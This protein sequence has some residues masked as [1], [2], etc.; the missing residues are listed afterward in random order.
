MTS[1]DA[2][3]SDASFV[4]ATA[5]VPRGDRPD[6][7]LTAE[8]V[9]HALRNDELEMWFQPKLEIATG[10]IVG[11]EALLRWRHPEHGVL[12][13]AD[14]LSAADRSGL[15]PQI[16]RH[17][18]DQSLMVAARWRAA[19]LLMPVAVNVD[20]ADLADPSLAHH[21]EALLDAHDLP[22]EL[23]LLE[24]TENAVLQD[25]ADTSTSVEQL[26][27]LGVRLAI[28]DFGVGYS[29]LSRLVQFQLAELKVDMSLIQAMRTSAQ[30]TTA[31]R[32]VIDLGHALGMRVVA[33]GV[34]D[35]R[36]L[37]SLRSLGCDTAQGYLVAAAMPADD[38]HAWV[39]ER[40]T[41]TGRCAPAAGRTAGGRGWWLHG[42]TQVIQAVGWPAVTTAALLVTAYVCWQVFRWGG[43][44]HQHLIGDLAFVPVNGGAAVAAAVAAWVHRRDQATR[45]AWIWL[46]AALTSY[47][48]GDVVQMYYELGLHA[49]LP[50][51]SGADLGYLTFYPMAFLGL[52]SLPTPRRSREQRFT[53]AFDVGTVVLGGSAVIWSMDL[54]PTVAAGGPDILA[55]LTSLAYPVGDLVLLFG[56]VSLLLR[57]PAAGGPVRLLL[58]G[59][60][61]YLVTD[62]LYSHIQLT[63]AYQGGDLVDT[64]WILAHAALGLAAV[65]Y[66][67]RP[68]LASQDTRQ[69]RT[70]RR[71]TSLPYLAI[72]VGYLT[73]ILASRHASWNPLGG[74]ILVTAALTAVVTVRQWTSLR[75][76][77]RLLDKYH[78]LAATDALTGLASRR[79]L[80]ELAESEFDHAMRSH[81]PL[82]VLMIDVDHFKQINDRFGHHTGDQVLCTVAEICRNQLRPQDL[83]GRYGGDELIAVLPD[84][85]AHGAVVVATRL[86]ERLRHLFEHDQV[87][88]ALTTL[89]IGVAE[90]ADTRSLDALLARADTALYNA[91]DEGRD[92]TR[93]YS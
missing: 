34:E 40:R 13:P 28:D 83:I 18:L 9:I 38:L 14:I 29:S 5:S 10:Q 27:R 84:T 47:L 46:G 67:R 15:M 81:H 77:S 50:F 36:V 86:Q 69:A 75:E 8:N 62:M 66:A 56:S 73:L 78:T 51:P 41:G 42:W 25:L 70:D 72:G 53:V 90:L 17:V 64:G 44:Q 19:G 58:L 80:L 3:T 20:P 6:T 92:C 93:T 76:N 39:G 82:S 63:G 68:T 24:V 1:V 11:A 59:F 60:G 7:P 35:E 37:T 32:A 89:S 33:E 22:G 88:P 48:L 55:L 12:G 16:T 87:G 54:G 21:V 26:R 23:L 31:V 52:L 45:R 2:W 43:P 49:D 91:K 79:R 30:A 74:L 85:D 65:A 4:A 71:H 61:S 57:V